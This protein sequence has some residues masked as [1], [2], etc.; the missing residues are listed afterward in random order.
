MNPIPKLKS[1]L[2]AAGVIAVL[3]TPVA[4]AAPPP[5]GFADLVEKVSPSVVTITTTQNVKDNRVAEFDQT[6]PPG[7]PF[8][9]FFKRFGIPDQQGPAQPMHALGSGFV[10]DPSGYIVTNYHVIDGAD[11]IKVRLAKDKEYDAKVIGKDKDTDLALLKIDAKEPLPAVPLGDSDK[12]RVGDTVIAVGNPFGLGGT[13][14]AGI[15][16]ALGREHDMMGHSLGPSNSNYVDFIQTDA[17]INK[18]N[19]GG[20]LFDVAG[21]VV[22]VNSAIVSPNGGSVGVGFAI[23]SNLVKSVVAQLKASG[24]VKRGW[25]GVMIQNVTPDIAEATG[26]KEPKGALIVSVNN[27]GPSAGKLKSGDI[28]LKFDGKEVPSEDELPRIVAATPQG[29]VV[30][31][32][33]MRD[34]KAE[35]VSIAVGKRTEAQVASLEKN[36][37]QGT[38]KGS[39]VDKLGATVAALTPE[40]RQQYNVD[41]DINGVVVTDVTSKTEA[42]ENGLR[43]G[44]VIQKVGSQPVTTPKELASAIDKLTTKSA[45]LYISR[46]NNQLFLG[47]PIA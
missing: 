42:M 2:A 11:S 36:G 24:S 39:A 13:V 20:P 28:I 19:S 23:P 1:A 17:A 27:D 12:L 31:V 45:L 4:I 32:E 33:I 6:F 37:D 44:D 38:T 41:D 16:S 8:E 15:V 40:L 29:K 3:W 43:E 22:G 46:G 10:I 26:L 18:G 35:T 34:G 30:P 14:T 25:L 47:V 5:Q 7:S 9:Q 21:E